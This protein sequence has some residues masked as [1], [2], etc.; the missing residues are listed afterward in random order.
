M[1]LITIDEYADRMRVGVPTVRHWRRTGYGP[2]PR[3]IGRRLLWLEA[4]V[5]SF[6]A[7][8]FGVADAS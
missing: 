4:E 3:R 7:A 1:R 2:Q 5:D 8:K 6:I